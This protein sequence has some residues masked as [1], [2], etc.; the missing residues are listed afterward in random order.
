MEKIERS[1]HFHTIHFKTT[2]DLHL[3]VIVNLLIMSKVN[4]DFA[5]EFGSVVPPVLVNY[6]NDGDNDVVS[7]AGPP[8]SVTDNTTVVNDVG[9]VA[10]PPPLP[11]VTENTEAVTTLT[12]YQ[13]MCVG[14]AKSKPVNFDAQG[15]AI[16][17]EKKI[18]TPKNTLSA[19]G[20]KTIEFNGFCVSL[21]GDVPSA[22]LVTPDKVFGFLYYQAHRPKFTKKT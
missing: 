11:S 20:P 19:Y 15:A 2:K 4:A 3:L 9:T 12:L 18:N 5:S 21:Y 7:V 6:N 1:Q 13:K 22:L 17:Q 16:T 8:A 14:M 10:A